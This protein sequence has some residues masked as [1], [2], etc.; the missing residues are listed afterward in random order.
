MVLDVGGIDAGGGFRLGMGR[1]ERRVRGREGG[2]EGGVCTW[3]EEHICR[4]GDDGTET[5]WHE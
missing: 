3:V 2:R 1:V 5:G 4:L